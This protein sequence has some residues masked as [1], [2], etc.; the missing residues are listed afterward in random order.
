MEEAVLLLQLFLD[1]ELNK[2]RQ[3]RMHL[4]GS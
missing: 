2:I 3:E 4:A 1:E